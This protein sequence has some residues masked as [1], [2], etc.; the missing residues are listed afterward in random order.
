MTSDINEEIVSTLNEDALGQSV[1]ENTLVDLD[2]HSTTY[3]TPLTEEHLASHVVSR[4][5]GVEETKEKDGLEYNR[6]RVVDHE[7]ESFKNSTIHS[8]EA[9]K[10]DTLDR[11]SWMIKWFL[12]LNLVPLLWNEDI[13]RVFRRLPVYVNHSCFAG[14]VFIANNVKWFCKHLGLPFWFHCISAWLVA[15]GR[16]FG[17]HASCGG[18]LSVASV[19]G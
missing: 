9:P 11:Y 19:C 16:V 18:S 7:S 14:C 2:I 4:R 8:N 5:F 12:V 1:L 6:T 10:H 17:H 13:S 3:P 15:H